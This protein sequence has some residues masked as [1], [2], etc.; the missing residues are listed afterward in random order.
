MNNYIPAKNVSSYIEENEII[1]TE[2]EAAKYIRMSRSFLSKDRMNGYRHGHT[3][4]PEFIKLG[5]RAIRY[6]K[7]DLDAWITKHRIF[8]VLP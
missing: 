7:K 5:A 4:G 2:A 1:L 8:R 6:R 3:Q